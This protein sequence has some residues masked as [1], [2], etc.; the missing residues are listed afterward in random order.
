M[1]PNLVVL[2]KKQLDENAPELFER[3]QKDKEKEAAEHKQEEQQS[4]PICLKTKRY[5]CRIRY[6]HRISRIF[7][8]QGEQCTLSA[9]LMSI[10]GRCSPGSCRIQWIRVFVSQPW[11]KRF[12]KS[13]KYKDIY[14][15]DYQS[16]GVLKEG[17]DR[18]MNFYNSERFHESLDHETPHR[19]YGSKF[20]FGELEKVA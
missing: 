8:L 11:K 14:I 7:D 20:S 2:W 12:W 9:S 5:G 6:G 15:R 16:M 3:S 19:R 18:Y 1:H 13:L 17:V 10:R 4:S